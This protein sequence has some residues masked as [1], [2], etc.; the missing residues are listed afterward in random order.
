L[1]KRPIL[2]SKIS[3]GLEP[4]RI[5]ILPLEMETQLDKDTVQ[6]RSFGSAVDAFLRTVFDI[7]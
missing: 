3:D 4:R 2:E 6:V 5:N 7:A 1:I